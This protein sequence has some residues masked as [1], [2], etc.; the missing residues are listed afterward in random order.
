MTFANLLD[1]FNFLHFQ[2][3]PL[4]HYNYSDWV[5]HFLGAEIT[6]LIKFIKDELL[7]MSYSISSHH[8]MDKDNLG[9]NEMTL[10]NWKMKEPQYIWKN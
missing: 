3:R 5:Y 1:G 10:Y 2:E 4:L 7:A 6:I 8:K 9:G